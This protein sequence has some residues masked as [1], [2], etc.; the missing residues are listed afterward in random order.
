M[1]YAIFIATAIPAT[2]SAI[3][4]VSLG[5][6][7]GLVGL[8]GLPINLIGGAILLGA[9]ALPSI[10]GTVLSLAGGVFYGI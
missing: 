7:L 1:N 10:I 2:F 8:L 9:L 5:L 6:S 3:I 4:G